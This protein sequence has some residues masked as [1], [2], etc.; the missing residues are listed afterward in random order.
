M[1]MQSSLSSSSQDPDDV[2]FSASRLQKLRAVIVDLIEAKGVLTRKASLY[3]IVQ[4]SVLADPA[5]RYRI[6]RTVHITLSAV[7]YKDQHR[8]EHSRVP[9]VC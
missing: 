7:R 8:E 3:C 1:A 5:N 9:A 4:E 6:M 2:V